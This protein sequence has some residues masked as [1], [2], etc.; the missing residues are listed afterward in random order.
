MNKKKYSFYKELC[1][2]LSRDKLRIKT[3]VEDRPT[4]KIFNQLSRKFKVNFD[5][6]GKMNETKYPITLKFEMDDEGDLRYVEAGNKTF[7]RYYK[8]KE[9]GVYK[10]NIN[11]T[12]SVYANST[13][14]T[15]I[16]DLTKFKSFSLLK[17]KAKDDLIQ[18]YKDYTEGFKLIKELIKYDYRTANNN[19]LNLAK[20]IWYKLIGKNITFS[21]TC[22]KEEKY[23]YDAKRCGFRYSAPK[24]IYEG[25]YIK[26][27]VNSFYSSILVN[28][29]YILPIGEPVFKKYTQEEFDNLKFY[30]YGLYKCKITGD[31]NP[32]LFYKNI[33]NIYT[34][35]ELRIAKE[36]K[37][38]ITIIDEDDNFMYY[39]KRIHNHILF[40][41]YVDLL[42][43]HKKKCFLIKR[44]LNILWGGLCEKNKIIKK[45]DSKECS[46]LKDDDLEFQPTIDNEGNIISF[47]IIEEKKLF[48]YNSCRIAP[49][50]TSYGRYEYYNLIKNHHELLIKTHTDGFYIKMTEEEVNKH[51]DMGK[52]I[53]QIKIEPI[54]KKDKNK[55]VCKKLEI[56][57]NNT[58]IALE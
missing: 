8:S 38:I 23:I 16:K 15:N 4:T 13:L 3:N 54:D 30:P 35:L 44:L 47:S 46:I 34:H 20:R 5:I 25:D 28:N 1:K 17:F 43:P 33:N 7:N 39:P 24:G 52:N 6:D 37:Y 49:F 10:K 14:E 9:F 42:F 57:N 2:G 19:T 40:K 58:I 32:K 41:Q 27:D 51:F 18:E 36:Q 12:Y 11:N 22:K 21:K 53:G 56:I 31:I 29:R 55:Y 45:I 50:I 48:K 26:L